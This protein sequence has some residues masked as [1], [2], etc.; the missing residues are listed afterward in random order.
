MYIDW[1]NTKLASLWVDFE[2]AT[3]ICIEYVPTY[4]NIIVCVE[5]EF[6]IKPMCVTESAYF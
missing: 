5:F 4:Y 3:L 2:C 1:K 6:N